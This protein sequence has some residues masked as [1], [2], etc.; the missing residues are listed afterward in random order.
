M[1]SVLNGEGMALHRSMQIA[2]FW[3]VPWRWP[4]ES[5]EPHAPPS[6][7]DWST[8]HRQPIRSF[9][10]LSLSLSFS[11]LI[12]I[13]PSLG[14]LFSTA[15]LVLF[16]FGSFSL[17][18]PDLR[19]P[20]KS[21]QKHLVLVSRDVPLSLSLSLS[22]SHSCFSFLGPF[23][24]IL[25]FFFVLFA[26][27]TPVSACL[28]PRTA[29]DSFG[30]QAEIELTNQDRRLAPRPRFAPRCANNSIDRRPSFLLLLLLLL[31][32]LLFFFFFFCCRF[33]LP[34]P[35]EPPERCVPIDRATLFFFNSFFFFFG[36]LS[37]GRP[38]DFG[39]L[40]IVFFFIYFR[41]QRNRSG[42]Q[43]VRPTALAITTSIGTRWWLFFFFSKSFS[44]ENRKKKKERNKNGSHR[45]LH[46]LGEARPRKARRRR[47][48]RWWAAASRRP[49]KESS[50][51]S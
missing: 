31:F 19:R 16:S 23:F 14:R 8:V 6:P 21:R 17:T 15:I 51:R 5:P 3:L 49:Y 50:R 27:Q 37:I 39:R 33:D 7:P 48:R 32:L 10:S 1:E 22:L 44:K 9:L 20:M 30:P 2:S 18:G 12:I 46:R 38:I 28:P 25:F 4:S 24:S 45:H 43:P 13:H 35:C 26:N 40:S 47:R 42:R 11:F 29:I 41:S 34:R 36:S